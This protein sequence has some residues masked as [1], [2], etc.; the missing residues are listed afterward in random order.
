MRPRKI[1]LLAIAA[2]VGA[3]IGA[4]TVISAG[5]AHADTPGCVSQFWMY[6]LRGTT[7]TICDGPIKADGSWQRG[8]QF[9]ARSYI[10]AGNSYC[11]GSGYYSS[12]SYTPPRQVPEFDLRDFYA[13]TVDTVLPDE[14]G[15]IE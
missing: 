15:H 7:R 3:G 6:G 9:Y 4:A 1:R 11:Y 12:C 13:V 14:P 8:R 10:A 5:E 2:C